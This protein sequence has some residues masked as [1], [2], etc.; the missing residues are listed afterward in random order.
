MKR[1]EHRACFGGFQDVYQHESKSLGCTMNFGIYLP[2][3]AEAKKLPVV[4]WL[5]GLTCT[6]QNFITKAGAQRYASEHG[7][8]L[9]APDTSPRGEGIPN[10]DTYDL[11]IGAGFYVNATEGVWAKNYRMYD[12]MVHELPHLVE[13]N[14]PVSQLRGI[15]GHS[16]GGHGALM[17]ALRNPELYKSVSAFSPIVAPS[18][19]PWGEKAFSSYLGSDRKTWTE[20]DTVKLIS[21]AKKR[22]PLLVDQG[23]T[24]EFLATQLRPELLKNACE[25]SGHP[26]TL[27]LREGYDHSYYFIASFIGDHIKHHA[28]E[29]YALR[30]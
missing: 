8:I 9:V 18:Q 24:D 13:S 16:M 26:L 12:Y 17:I 10:A 25:I 22:L 23:L 19:V 4:Y 7:V 20:Y 29:L 21:N 3:E 27:N 11:G 6:E 15:S 5:S 14:F 1:I 30:S 2:K 28:K